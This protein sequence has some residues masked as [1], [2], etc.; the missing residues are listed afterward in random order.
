M[1]APQNSEALLTSYRS[2]S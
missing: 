1:I 2:K